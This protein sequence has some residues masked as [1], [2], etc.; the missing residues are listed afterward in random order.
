MSTLGM[1]FLLWQRGNELSKALRRLGA[2][3][4]RTGAKIDEGRLGRL[5]CEGL[6]RGSRPLISRSVGPLL[7]TLLEALAERGHR[8]SEAEGLGDVG[9]AHAGLVLG[10]AGQGVDGL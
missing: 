2:G 1:G 5:S 8:A 7:L 10:G 6:T 9:Q 4:G 3:P